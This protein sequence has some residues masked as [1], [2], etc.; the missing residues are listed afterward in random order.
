MAAAAAELKPQL[1]VNINGEAYEFPPGISILNATKQIGLI[2]PTL[3]HDPRIKPIGSCRLCSVEI[4]GEPRTQAACKAP[5][6]DGMRIVTHSPALEAFRAQMLSWMAEK[7]SPEA[8]ET[9]PDKELHRLMRQ[10]GVAPSRPKGP[11]QKPDLSN[12][13]IRVDM[14]QCIDCY[15]CV[16]ICDELQGQFVWHA[17]GRGQDTRVV[18]DIGETLAESSC[19]TCG[20]CADSCPTGALTD[21]FA[22]PAE[23]WTRT[24]C[25]YC[26]VGCELEA[27]SV[28]GRITQV[29]PVPDA[30]V[31]KGHLCVKGRYAFNYTNASDRQTAPLFRAG[32]NWQEASWDEALDR[33]A[34]ALT[35][36]LATYGPASIGVL[37][38]ARATNEDNYLTQKFARVVLGTNNVDCCARVCH[39]PSAAALKT[40]L[41]TGAATNSFNDIE[42][43]HTILVVGANPTECHPIVGARIKQQVLRGGANL[44]VIDPRRTE[45]AGLATIHLA[46]RPG[47]N[48]PLLNALAHVIVTEG[49]VD[50]DFVARRVRERDEFEAFIKEWSPERA[51]ALCG[52]VADDIRKAARLYATAKPS[53]AVHGLGVTEHLQGTEGV[54]GIINLALLT[55]N[56]GKP[57]TG[58]NPLRGQNN[59]QGSAQM[60][61]DPSIL[62]GSVALEERR[63]LFESVW[64][65]PVPRDHGLN[66]MGMMDAAAAGR[67]KALWVIGYDILPTL[68]NMPATR[69]ALERLDCVIVQDLFIT[70][71]AAAAGHLFFPAASNFE[72]DGTFMNGERRIQR[73]RQASDAPGSAKPD[74]WIISE[75]AKRM[76]HGTAFDYQSAEDVWNEVRRV[77]PEA[78]G[79]S[80][81][82]LESGGLQWPCRTEDDPGTT[83]LHVSDFTRPGPV[84]L[85][86]LDYVATPERVSEE[87]PLLLSTGRNLYQFNAGTMTMRTRNT[88]LRRTDTLDISPAD[89]ARLGVH[90]GAKVRVR[91][92]YG[93]VVMEARVTDAIR[94]GMAF[95]T[96]H[97][98]R[99]GLNKLTSPVRDRIVQAPEYKVTAISVEPAPP[100]T[101]NRGGQGGQALGS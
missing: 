41:G 70:K 71:T 43:A 22:V 85:Q 49:L 10:Y 62:T 53:M 67:L 77:W 69:A 50:P 82:R 75:L 95:A 11:I 32:R 14:S 7:V 61:C 36:T 100:R 35:R 76:G 54:M 8:F 57:G 81:A 72:K 18:P 27:A 66:L 55:G 79:V 87:F 88:K 51:A 56:I 26:G 80:Y 2:V 38:S 33:A 23:S 64:G 28:N 59:V 91:S 89:S 1:Q 24:T 6:R 21:R 84:A 31:S 63:T 58:V 78:A 44:I 101:A 45:T 73:V 92:R 39:T 29:R 46:L 5:L 99:V 68:A 40:M 94:P 15:R 30:P 86:R 17:L 42:R 74:W 12:P 13:Y 65:A 48:I 4:V 47:T 90:T 16:H 20:A 19:V 97:D 93:A 37:G 96:F 52:V 34:E 98:P 3:C 9:Y 83:I 60:G 25:V